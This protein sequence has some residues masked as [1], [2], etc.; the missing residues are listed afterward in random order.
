LATIRWWM[1]QAHRLLASSA[2]GTDAILVAGY[3]SSD[4]R[5]NLRGSRLRVIGNGLDKRTA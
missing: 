1:W 5:Q 4:H 2:C 3:S